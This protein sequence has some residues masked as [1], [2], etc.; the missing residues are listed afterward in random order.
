MSIEAPERTPDTLFPDE[1]EYQQLLGRRT[2]KARGFELLCLMMLT[3]AVLALATLLYT[4]INDAFGLVAIVNERQPEDIVAELGHDPETMTLSGLEKDEL[5]TLLEETVSSGV[6]RRLERDQRFYEDRLV[7]ESQTVWDEIC[8]GAEAPPGCTAGVRDQPNVFAIVQERVVVP[9][10][11]ASYKLV[12]S[13]LNG[14]QFRTDIADIFE[15]SPE[16]FGDYTFDQVEFEFRAWF[17]PTFLRTPSSST[18]EIAGIRTAILGSAWLMVIT[19]LFAVPVGVGAAV[20][21][22]EFAKPS[23]FNEIVQTNIYNLAGVPSIIYGMLGLAVLVRVLEPITSGAVFTD[24]VPPSENGRTVL[25]AGITLGLLI[26]P[27]VIISAQEALKA[28]PNSLRHAGLALGA[29]QWQT[30]RSQVIPVA[31]PGILTGT[32]LA[33]SRAIGETAPLILV[34]AASFITSDPTGPFSKFT[35]L[36]I[37]I[38]QWTGFPQQEFRNIAAAASIAL[39]LLLLI[40]NAFAVILRNRYARKA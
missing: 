34:G 7:F 19:L 29:T 6:G 10:V 39:L 13:I 15:N 21:L 1:Q 32:I 35:A 4:I 37:Q 24:G 16:R 31:L 28:V 27:V 38:F 11:I 30:V 18:P 23:R 40:L 2:R 5:V 12:P 25:S 26:L 36:P 9:D 22:T 17:N 3:L 14:D 33:V 20:Y 8:A